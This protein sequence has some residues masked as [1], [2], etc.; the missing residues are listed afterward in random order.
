MSKN[1]HLTDSERF[2]IEQWLRQQVSIKKIAGYLG[3]SA[4][5]ISREIRNRSVSSDKSAP[6][7]EF[8]TDASIGLTA[9]Y[10]PCVVI[11]QI[12]LPFADHVSS[13]TTDVRTSMRKF[14]KSYP[15]RLMSVM[16]V[17]MSITAF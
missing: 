17:Q 13:A 10:A 4:S 16:D 11:N 14:A 5:T 1:K 9:Q 6:F 7:A 8:Q 2:Q 3:K 15:R 12:A